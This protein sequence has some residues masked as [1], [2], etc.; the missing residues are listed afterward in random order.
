[1]SAEIFGP[2]LLIVLF[3]LVP[4][5]AIWVA[6]DAS[7]KPPWAYE[8]AGQN[9]TLWIVLP[10]VGIFTCGLVTIAVAIVWFA[11]IRPKVVAAAAGGYPS[12]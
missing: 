8:R 2:E 7:S 11:S 10:I 9:K 5:L 12:A 4:V 3:L 6:V 1:M